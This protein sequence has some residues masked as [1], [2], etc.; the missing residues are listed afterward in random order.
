MTPITVEL[1]DSW[2]YGSAS[3]AESKGKGKG[4]ASEDSPLSQSASSVK[5]RD[6]AWVRAWVSQLNDPVLATEMRS[7][8]TALRNTWEPNLTADS[9]SLIAHAVTDARAAHNVWE[10]CVRNQADQAAIDAA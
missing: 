5:N 8:V 9:V 6:S 3:P 7:Q 4:G 1:L 2:D 10:G